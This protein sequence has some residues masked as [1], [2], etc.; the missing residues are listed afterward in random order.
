VVIDLGGFAGHELVEA[1]AAAGARLWQVLGYGLENID[2]GH[3]LDQ[4]LMLAHTPGPTSALA[5]AEHAFF[6]MLCVEKNLHAGQANLRAGV[7]WR[8]FSGEL[9]GQTLAIV[10]LGASGRELAKRAA[11]FGMRVVAVDVAEIGPEVLREHGVDFCGNLDALDRILGEADYVSLHVPLTRATHHM[12][13]ARVL[14]LMK[15]TAVL[16]NVSRGAVVDE[17]ALVDVLRAGRLRGAGLDVLEKEPPPPD[18]PLLTLD[19][20]VVTPHVAGVSWQTSKRRARVA[21]EN[22]IRVARGEEPLGLVTRES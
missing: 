9:N 20:V 10:G 22:V 5:L 14:D 4:G 19:N 3:V 2:I 6:L 16:V 17:R 13:D 21:A 18:H 7:L 15:P 11:V 1:G 8:P 12:I